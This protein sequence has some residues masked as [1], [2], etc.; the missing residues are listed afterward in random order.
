[1]TDSLNLESKLDF[2]KEDLTEPLTVVSQIAS[3]VVEETHSYVKCE[4]KK[5][6]GPTDSYSETNGIMTM[7]D[8]LAASSHIHNIQNDLG[9]I[10]STECKYEMFLAASKFPNYKFRILFFTYKIGGYPVDLILEQGV[11]NEFNVDGKGNYRVRVNSADELKQSIILII[12]TKRI[13][14]IIQALIDA[15]RQ[16]PNS[17]E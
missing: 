4:I 14:D 16:E 1:M 17:V 11:A 12:S 13:I 3:K 8:L 9:E 7:V 2:Q 15:S 10:E 5:Y 6:D